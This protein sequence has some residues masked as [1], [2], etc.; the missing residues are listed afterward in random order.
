MGLRHALRKFFIGVDEKSAPTAAVER[1]EI[2][3]PEGQRHYLKAV[4]TRLAAEKRPLVIVLHGSGASAEQVLGLAFPYSP[5]S[6]WLEIAEREQVVVIAPDGCKR[7]GQRAWN[8]GFAGIA[9]NPQCDDVAFIEAIIERA[10]TEDDIDPE[11]VYLI[12]VSKGGMMAYR[13]AAEIPHRLAAF[14][15]VL[16]AMP[17]H[18][19]YSVP[20]QA[21][22][23]L[24][25]AGTDDPFI[26]YKGGKSIITLGFTA[27]ALG[28]EATAA[29]WCKLAGLAG[30]PAI[31]GSTGAIRQTWGDLPGSL[32][33][34][35][36]TIVGGGHA[37][38]SRKKRYPGLFSRFPGRQS[39]ELEIAEEAWAFFQNKRRA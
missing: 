16:A 10:I 6:V 26:P 2:M 14:S 21:L 32:Q 33:V 27:P 31:S 12:G 18:A 15:A 35:L 1:V 28:I 23:A 17:Q 3:R 5:L 24:I 29:L 11:R 7:R 38:P 19:A 4:P 22:S 13:I 8:D 39:A 30:P 25:V 9:S 34:V 20:G 36:L 37:E